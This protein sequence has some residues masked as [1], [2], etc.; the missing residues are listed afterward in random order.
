MWVEVTLRDGNSATLPWE[1]CLIACPPL[2]HPGQGKSDASIP[3]GCTSAPCKR[4][5]N[6]SSKKQGSRLGSASRNMGPRRQRTFRGQRKVDEHEKREVGDSFLQS[7]GIRK[8]AGE[9]A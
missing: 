5:K 1:A 7:V 9:K 8:F 4:Q 6:G 2:K 3:Q